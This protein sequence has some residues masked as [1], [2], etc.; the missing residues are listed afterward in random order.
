MSINLP[1]SLQSAL[2]IGGVNVETDAFA[3][4]TAIDIDFLSKTVTISVQQ[5]T[6]SGQ[7]FTVGQVPPAYKISINLLTGA[8]SVNNAN[9]SSG[10]LSGAVLTNL[11]NTFLNMRNATENFAVNQGIFPGATVTGWTQI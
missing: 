6:T 2:T 7:T 8:W 1:A 4:I 5:G 11:Q 9:N 3:S 10:T